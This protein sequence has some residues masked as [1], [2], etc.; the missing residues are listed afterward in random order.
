MS[1]KKIHLKKKERWPRGQPAGQ[2]PIM[3]LCSCYSP[4]EMLFLLYSDFLNQQFLI[5]KGLKT[6]LRVKANTHILRALHLIPLIMWIGVTLFHR[7][8]N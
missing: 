1:E 8:G 5:F 3:T 2:K 6:P 7:R 4:L